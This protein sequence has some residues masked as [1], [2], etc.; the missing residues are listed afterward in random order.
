MCRSV[1]SGA[2]KEKSLHDALLHLKIPTL[3]QLGQHII[4]SCSFRPRASLNCYIAL[5]F[6]CW[7]H[8]TKQANEDTPLWQYKN[9]QAPDTLLAVGSISDGCQVPLHPFMAMYHLLFCNLQ[10][11]NAMCMQ[12]LGCQSTGTHSI[13]EAQFCFVSTKHRGRIETR[14][15]V[16]D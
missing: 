5:M 12:I 14:R 15:L 10:S 3:V 1:I 9:P 6:P 13:S 2:E 4:F 7:A 16:R 11:P 8:I